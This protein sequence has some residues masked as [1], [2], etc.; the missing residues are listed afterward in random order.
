M[1][2]SY[3]GGGYGAGGGGGGGGGPMK[4]GGFSQR[5]QGPYGGRCN[6]RINTLKFED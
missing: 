3:G 2:E 4:S 5:G 1:S 6:S